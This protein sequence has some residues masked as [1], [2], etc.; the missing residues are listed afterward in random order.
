MRLRRSC[1]PTSR[2]NRSFADI[3]TIKDVE[4]SVFGST[5]PPIIAEK[6]ARFTPRQLQI[7]DLTTQFRSIED[8]ARLL[9]IDKDTVEVERTKIM[10]ELNLSSV[11]DV[12]LFAQSRYKYLLP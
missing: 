12:V 9:R 1:A 8:I 10:Q 7:I 11:G 4:P 6:I 2:A 3:K 5:V